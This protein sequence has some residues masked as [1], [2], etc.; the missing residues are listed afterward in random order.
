[1]V[2]QCIV[3]DCFSTP[4][5]SVTL[6]VIA[7]SGIAITY[8]LTNINYTYSYMYV[9]FNVCTQWQCIVFKNPHNNIMTYDL[10]KTS[11]ALWTR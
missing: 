8:I 5:Y 4:K 1:M 7:I 10:S 6:K 9:Y 2:K 3:A 11:M